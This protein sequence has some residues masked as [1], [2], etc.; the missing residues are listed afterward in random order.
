MRVRGVLYLIAAL[1][2]T[3][4]VA[5]EDDSFNP[6]TAPAPDDTVYAGEIFNIRWTNNTAD[7]ISLVL[8]FWGTDQNWILADN[9]PNLGVYQWWV[10]SRI[11]L[12]SIP[13]TLGI[14]IGSKCTSTTAV[15]EIRLGRM[16]TRTLVMRAT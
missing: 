11:Q 8:Y 3:T 12:S 16:R 4:V 14:R 15:S 10:K 5:V 2:F 6:I 1:L 7:P 9:I 13:F